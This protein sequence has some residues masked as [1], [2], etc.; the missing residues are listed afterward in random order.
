M[1]TLPQINRNVTFILRLLPLFNIT[2][3]SKYN[4]S[5]HI[6]FNEISDAT[7]KNIV[8]NVTLKNNQSNDK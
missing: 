5:I 2:T 4:V 6:F 7:I 8:S 3:H 1:L